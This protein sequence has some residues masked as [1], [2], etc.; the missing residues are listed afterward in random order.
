MSATP[1]AT[2]SC[3]R[4][5]SFA[6]SL[7]FI[8]GG[9]LVM[10]MVFSYQ[11][12]GYVL[13]S[14]V[15]AHDYPLMQGC[16][17]VITLAVLVANIARR[18]RSTPCSTRGP[19]RRADMAIDP[20]LP[21]RPS[22]RPGRRDGGRPAAPASSGSLLPAQRASPS[23]ASS[24]L[25]FFVAPRDHRAV[26]RPVRPE[27]AER[28]TS[29]QPPSHDALAGHHPPGPGHPVASSS[30]APAACCRRLRRRHRS[31]RCIGVI[32]GVTAG[33]HRRVGDE[34][35]SAL[36][37]IF[38]VHPAAAAHHHHRG[39]A[40]VAGGVTV[41]ARASPST[42]WAWGARV[43]RAQTLSLRRRDFVEAARANG[44]S[45]WRIIIAEILPNLTAIIAVG[46]RRHRVFAVL[47]QITLAFI[48][49]DVD[50]RLE[51]GH[52][53]CSGRRTSQAL[54]RGAWWW[55]VPAGLCIALRRHGA[56]ARQL[57]HRRVRQ[58]AAARVGINAR[59]LRKRGI[60]PRIGFT[61]VV[62]E[63]RERPAHRASPS[64]APDRQ[65]VR[66]RTPLGRRA[67]ARD[68]EPVGRLRV[69][70]RPDARAARRLAHPATAAR[71][72]AWPASRAAASRRSR[73]RRPACCR[74]PA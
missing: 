6:L 64:T 43:L 68:Q 32:V 46:L 35:L 50:H 17:L 37:N 2:R 65:R 51:L 22:T 39:P 25:G 59:A 27:R 31:P 38:L 52:R 12:I 23:P 7:G 56:D 8:V 70:R 49:I 18:L 40:A 33:L 29:L 42:G 69:R 61:P 57:R 55:F 9:T 62:Y 63:A 26:D 73:T 48:G 41:A 21:S 66:G 67:R 10:E 34:A 72:S 60:R 28:A 53:S 71:C 3:R 45:T 30:S 13:F 24:I 14:A 1:P 44:E 15:N 19:G 4:S 5:P 36:S 47:A 11:G 20:S 58:P 74:R 54:Q 16:F